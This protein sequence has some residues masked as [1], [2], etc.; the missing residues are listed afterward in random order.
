MIPFYCALRNQNLRFVKIRNRNTHTKKMKLPVFN[1]GKNQRWIETEMF[2]SKDVFLMR[3][4]ST[5]TSPTLLPQA[6]SLVPSLPSTQIPTWPS[7]LLQCSP[8]CLPESLPVLLHGSLHGSR[9]GVLPDS[10]PPFLPAFSSINQCLHFL[11]YCYYF[12]YIF[13]LG[14]I[15]RNKRFPLVRKG[16]KCHFLFIID[17]LHLLEPITDFIYKLGFLEINDSFS[18][19]SY[20]Q[21]NICFFFFRENQ[22]LHR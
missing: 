18:T 8:G 11:H 3:F 15:L 9:H 16:Q 21:T 5:T 19:S 4:E 7:L 22:P 13:K 2:F 10:L 12:F 6:P 14:A 17:A 20:F 1:R